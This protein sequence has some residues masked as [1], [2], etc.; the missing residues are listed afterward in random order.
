MHVLPPEGFAFLEDLADNNHRE[1]FQAHKKRYEQTVKEPAL[2]FIRAMEEP[3]ARLSPNYLAVPKAVG[4]SLFRIYRDTRFSKDKTPYKTHTGVQFRHEQ[5]SRDI[6][7]PGFYLHL[8]PGE[9]SVGV[10]AYM[11]PPPL[12]GAIRAYID[13]QPEAWQ[14]LSDEL[15]ATGFS[16]MVA[17][18]DL[19]RNPRGYPKDHPMGPILRRKS[20]AVHRPLEQKVL[21]GEGGLD[22]VVEGFRQAAPLVERLCA[23]AELPY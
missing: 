10:G 11:P 15:A 4:G 17:D 13:A 6:H 3:L 20:H 7:A 22:A 2:A 9:C 23:I 8:A 14:A 16:W 18:S 5:S 1:W 12:L 21:Q 19:K